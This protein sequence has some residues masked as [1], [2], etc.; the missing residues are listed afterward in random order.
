[1]LLFEERLGLPFPRLAVV[2]M[3][4][5]FFFSRGGPI[6]DLQKWYPVDRLI[7]NCG[8]SLRISGEN[9]SL[10]VGESPLVPPP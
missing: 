7:W 2:G 8:P 1:V 6:Q 3:S 10:S 4:K 5:F 9:E